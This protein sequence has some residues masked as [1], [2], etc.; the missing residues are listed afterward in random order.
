MRTLRRKME[1][2]RLANLGAKSRSLLARNK[3]N[4]IK[5]ADGVYK[6]PTKKR[7]CQDIEG[8]VI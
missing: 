7:R 6:H 4:Y 5:I 2:T 1:Q 3:S 8:D